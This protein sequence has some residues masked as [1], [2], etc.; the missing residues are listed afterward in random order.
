MKFF[1]KQ[2]KPGRKFGL[3]TTSLLNH[4]TERLFLIIYRYSIN[5]IRKKLHGKQLSTENF[6]YIT[7][8]FRIIFY[9]IIP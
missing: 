1:I 8:L 4:V 3:K 7:G 6:N 9:V 5:N 2:D